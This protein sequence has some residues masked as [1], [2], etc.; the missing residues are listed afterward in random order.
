MVG[1]SDRDR[2]S[3]L[4]CTYEHSYGGVSGAVATILGAAREEAA[5]GGGTGGWEVVYAQGSNILTPLP[6]GTVAAAAA[7][8][9]AQ[10][11]L[12]V[13]G[14][15][16][17]VE[18]EG[19][20]RTTLRLP[21]AQ[22]EL[23]AAVAAAATQGPLILV[24]VS[25][26]LVDTNFSAPAAVVQLWYPGSEAGHGLWDVVMGRVSPSGRLPLSAYR[27]PYLAALHDTI[28]NFSLVSST[29]VGKTYR[30]ADDSSAYIN[31]WFGYGLSY[32]A[33]N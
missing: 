26:G 32:G 11:T 7:A 18:E 20:D 3:P 16:L 15:G 27:E 25:G 10:A 12:L 30:Y 1:V 8:A 9:S 29:G 17:L 28:A 21:G 19:L 5:G 24:L 23:L 33:F 4:Q 31:Y 6:N 14:L 13:L 22:E 2:D